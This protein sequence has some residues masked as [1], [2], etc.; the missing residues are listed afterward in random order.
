MI[1]DGQHN[2]ISRP[3]TAANVVMSVFGQTAEENLAAVQ[4][5]FACQLGRL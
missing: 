3:G 4:R 5:T 1:I 2:W